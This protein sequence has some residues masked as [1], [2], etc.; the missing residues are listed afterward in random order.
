M[1]R[2][3]NEVARII[4]SCGSNQK[5]RLQRGIKR[6]RLMAEAIER[7]EPVSGT[8]VDWL[9]STYLEILNTV[10]RCAEKFNSENPDDLISNDDFGD[11]LLTTLRNWEEDQ[12][13]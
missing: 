2:D 6:R 7:G 11:A 12:N 9:V 5:I 3:I 4:S 1:T 8:R 13:D 10:G